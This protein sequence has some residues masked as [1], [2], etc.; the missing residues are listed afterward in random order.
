MYYKER[1][2]A[3]SREASPEG[4]YHGRS[5]SHSPTRNRAK[6]SERNTPPTPLGGDDTQDFPS[7]EHSPSDVDNKFSDYKRSG[8]DDFDITEADIQELRTSKYSSAHRKESLSRSEER[9][10]RKRS[11]EDTFTRDS[12]SK[13]ESNVRKLDRQLSHGSHEKMSLSLLL[14]SSNC[15][16]FS[17]KSCFSCCNFDSSPPVM[18]A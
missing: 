16:N 18:E 6:D 12:L 9:Y 7:Q 2:V 10:S 5:W 15:F 17:I 11:Y 3:G 14:V 1:Y 8:K 13:E 4:S